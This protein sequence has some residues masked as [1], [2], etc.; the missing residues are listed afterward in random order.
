MEVTERRTMQNWAWAM[1]AVVDGS[2][3]STD[4]ITVLLDNLNT[5][6]PTALYAA[7]PPTETRRLQQ[8]LEFIYTPKDGSWLNM[9]EIELSALS[10]Q[11][12]NRRLG[13]RDTVTRE[14]SAWEQRRNDAGVTVDWRFT[15]ADARIKLKRLYPVIDI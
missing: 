1:K 2:Y 13:D 3:P 14:V 12:L 7:F 15:T 11:C 9:A 5:H 8:R 10:R 4:L 6:V